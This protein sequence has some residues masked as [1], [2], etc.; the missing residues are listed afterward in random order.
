ME[1]M[2][3]QRL[4]YTYSVNIMDKYFDRLRE[5][6]FYSQGLE[7]FLHLWSL[8]QVLVEGEEVLKLELGGADGV[9]L[10]GR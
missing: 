8:R 3:I 2:D 9:A 6:I 4:K 10:A 7:D 1:S 5:M